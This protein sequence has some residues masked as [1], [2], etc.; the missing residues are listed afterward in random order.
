MPRDNQERKAIYH[1]RQQAGK[2]DLRFMLLFFFLGLCLYTAFGY[3]LIRNMQLTDINLLSQFLLYGIAT[4]VMWCIPI[5]ML[6]KYNRLGRP[7][8]LLCT[9]ASIYLYRNAVGY[10]E[11]K[12]TPEF[13]KYMFLSL[14]ICKCCLILYCSGKLLVSRTIRSIWDFGDLYDDELEALDQMEIAVP[15]ERLPK[16]M[17]KAKLMLKRCSL[18]LGAC[19]YA[20]TILI[21]IGLSVFSTSIPSYTEAI[22]AIQYPLFSECLFSIMVW[23]VPIFG[24]YMGKQ[25]SPY[26]LLLPMLGEILRNVISFQDILGIFSNQLIPIEIAFLYIMLTIGRYMLL[27][28]SCRIVLKSRLIKDYMRGRKMEK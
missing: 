10:L 7:I 21:F 12:I 11:L 2:Q 22:G 3:Y 24:M 8:F 27:L 25:W 15:E 13:Y 16:W 5:R 26:L 1:V 23:S 14:F 19:L 9:C 17:E 4:C 6:W 28:M 18:R 20:S